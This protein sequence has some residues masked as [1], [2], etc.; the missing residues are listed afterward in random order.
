MEVSVV[1]PTHNRADALDKTLLYLGQQVFKHS[2]EVIIVNNNCTDETDTVAARHQ[3]VFPVP[4]ILVHEAK[5]GAAAA[6]NAG[7]RKAT[8]DYLIFID[9]DILTEPD[10]LQ[11]H[12]DNLIK[13]KKC[14]FVGY[15]CNLPEQEA[16]HFGKFKKSLEPDPEP[17]VT[18]IDIITGQTTSMLKEDF[19]LLGGF[20]EQFHVASGEDR[21]L[22]IRAKKSGIRIFLD[23][24]IRV[25][26]N[27]WAGTTISDYCQRQRLYSQT[28]P[29]FWKKY[30]D[31]TPRLKM[32][33]ECLPPSLKM[34][35]FKL[36]C[37]KKVKGALATNT[38]QK[39]IFACCSFLERSLPVKL[40]LWRLYRL[41]IAGAI[42]R[43]FNEGIKMFIMKQ[44]KLDN[45]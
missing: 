45:L 8:G 4:L 19:E 27:D 38:G 15:V 9:N 6:R 20:D 44:N 17:F 7:A 11:R 29:F 18:E 40:I 25:L 42:Y 34:D 14:W 26:H 36:F 2:W 30:G 28:E 32:V 24:Q 37:W 23:P 43:G 1:I 3:Q 35:G 5:P 41:A 16:T 31:E 22:A 39:I 33:R 13:E 21:E 12:Y 10:F